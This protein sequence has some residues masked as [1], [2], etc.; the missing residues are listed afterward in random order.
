VS[1]DGFY[2]GSAVLQDHNTYRECTFREGKITHCGRPFD[3]RAIVSVEGIFKTCEMA[4]GKIY[5]CVGWAQGHAPSWKAD[6][7]A[8]DPIF[9][10]ERSMTARVEKAKALLAAP[11]K[12]A[13]V[14]SK[15]TAKVKTVKTKKAVK[16]AKK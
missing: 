7:G 5:R 13:N 15:A 12:A 11:V 6:D 4:E 16:T 14:N 9:P 3:G 10:S 2:E 1:C 8:A